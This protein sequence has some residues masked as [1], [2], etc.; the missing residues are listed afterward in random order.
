MKIVIH[1]STMWTV[2]FTVLITLFVGVDLENQD[3]RLISRMSPDLGPRFSI[4]QLFSGIEQLF[5]DDEESFDSTLTDGQEINR[6]Q[7]ISK[8]QTPEPQPR[9]SFRLPTPA[10]GCGLSKV[11]KKKR[12]VGGAPAQN[13]AWPWMALLGTYFFFLNNF[14]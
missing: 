5:S 13:G 11:K 12:I 10:D 3:D 6:P 1:T 14:V 8:P 7:I 2:Y 9:A 4:A